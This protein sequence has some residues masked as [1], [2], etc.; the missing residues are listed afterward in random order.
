[1]AEMSPREDARFQPMVDSYRS[2][3]VRWIFLTGNRGVV[4]LGITGAF[5][6]FFVCLVLAGAVPLEYTQPLYYA[7]S[8][9]I[10]GNLTLITVI[11]SINQLFLS[12]ELRTPGELQTQIENIIEYRKGIEHAMGEIAPSTPLEFLRI[13][14]EGT[15]QKA[16]QLDEYVSD[17]VVTSGQE[18]VDDV[19][20]TLTNQMEQIEKPLSGPQPDTFNVLSVMLGTNYSQHI[21]RLRLIRADHEDEIGDVAS[22][23]ID[24]LIQR[25]QDIDVSRQYFRSIYLQEE[26][27]ALSRVLLYTGLP[28]VAIAIATLVVLTVPPESPEIFV[29]LRVLLPVTLTIGLVPLAILCSFFLRAATV[30]KLT[31]ATVPFTTP[32][33]ARL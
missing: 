11:V 3:G 29:D 9:L 1:M 31:A 8:G 22:E 30:T 6:T 14:I 25:L 27:S 13:L 33:D 18:E 23:A 24:D 19:V 4:A 2:K 7:Y 21:Y 20:T 15:R 17:G 5:A 16:R 28:S 32:E 12:R 10:A 26:L